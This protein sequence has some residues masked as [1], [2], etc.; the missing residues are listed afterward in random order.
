[1]AM[2]AVRGV[3]AVGGSYS[4]CRQLELAPCRARFVLAPPQR[5]PDTMTRMIRILSLASA[6]TGVAAV[7]TVT[8][9]GGGL[10]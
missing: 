6:V 10:P 7:P 3:T 2:A 1:M 9:N 8:V 4:I 5:N